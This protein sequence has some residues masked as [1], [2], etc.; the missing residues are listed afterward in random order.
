M[1]GVNVQRAATSVPE[2]NNT[3]NGG[4]SFSDRNPMHYMDKCLLVS[5][6]VVPL[7]YLSV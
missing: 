1:S 4:A 3:S 5:M 7:S 6:Q 2:N